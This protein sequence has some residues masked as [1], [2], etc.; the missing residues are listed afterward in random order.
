[1]NKISEAG[2]WNDEA[3]SWLLLLKIAT[4]DFFFVFFFP[5]S[6]AWQLKC[7]TVTLYVFCVILNKYR[8]I[9]AKVVLARITSVF[10]TVPTIAK[11]RVKG[12]N[13]FNFFR[14]T[15]WKLVELVSSLL[16]DAQ[17]FVVTW[18]QRGICRTVYNFC[19]LHSLCFWFYWRNKMNYFGCIW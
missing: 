15:S 16:F 2:S 14:R 17:F 19:C 6:G 5:P 13:A 10:L 3:C 1:M 18:Q 7:L 8:F 4:F 12:Y 11:G 9:N